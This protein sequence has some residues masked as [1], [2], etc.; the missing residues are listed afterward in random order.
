M[1]GS[2]LEPLLE[3]EWAWARLD[4]WFQDRAEA[5]ERTDEAL[6]Y[7][8]R[9]SA[10][11]RAR[12]DGEQFTKVE[13]RCRCGRVWEVHRHRETASIVVDKRQ[14]LGVQVTLEPSGPQGARRYRCRCGYERKLST[15]RLALRS[16]SAFDEGRSAIVAGVDL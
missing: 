6:S 4:A 3:Q 8:E 7:E 13:L 10:A 14:R 5:L 15:E 2:G 9:A 11:E 16:R 1:A 12:A